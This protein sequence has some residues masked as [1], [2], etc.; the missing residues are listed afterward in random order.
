MAVSIGGAALAR[1]CGG[2]T[3]PY[4]DALAVRLGLGGELLTAL[5]EHLD[6]HQRE[7]LPTPLVR[8]AQRLRK[9]LTATTM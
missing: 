8:R 6:G 3:E 5:E 7:A 9:Q 4:A 2:Q 1:W